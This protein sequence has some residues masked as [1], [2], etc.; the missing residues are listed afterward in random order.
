MTGAPADNICVNT[1]KDSG[2]DEPCLTGGNSAWDPDVP[3]ES[4]EDLG[5]DAG[6]TAQYWKA[7]TPCKATGCVM[8]GPPTVK[9]VLAT[10][11]FTNN[12]EF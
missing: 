10:I 5:Y 1:R 4:P 8:E 3:V 7:A 11:N 6:W 12:G 9:N 2:I